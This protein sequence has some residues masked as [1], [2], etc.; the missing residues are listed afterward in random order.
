MQ[1]SAVQKENTAPEEEIVIPDYVVLRPVDPRNYD[2]NDPFYSR[3]NQ[4]YLRRAIE[5]FEAGKFSY[6]DIIEIDDDE[7]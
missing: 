7:S 5:D 6:H 2:P 4:E 3:P 1:N